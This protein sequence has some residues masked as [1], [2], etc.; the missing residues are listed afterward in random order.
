MSFLEPGFFLVVLGAALLTNLA[1]R[2][3][4]LAAVAAAAAGLAIAALTAAATHLPAGFLAV[5]GA[6]FVLA[7]VLAF[8]SALLAGRGHRGARARIAAG[9]LLAGAVGLGRDGR[10]AIVAAPQGALL[11]AAVVL[12]VVG[13]GFFLVG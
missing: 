1:S 10:R 12:A 5:D 13:A 9:A 6:L 3:S 4:V 7:I 8:G 2:A 11:L